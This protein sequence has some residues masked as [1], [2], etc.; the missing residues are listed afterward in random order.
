MVSASLAELETNLIGFVKQIMDPLLVVFDF[1]EV[2]EEILGDVVEK[3]LA[4]ETV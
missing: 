1:Y 4:R 2:S 3:F